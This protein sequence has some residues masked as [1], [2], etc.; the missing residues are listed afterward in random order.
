VAGISFL[1]A[2]L[3][4]DQFGVGSIARGL[5]LAGFGVAGM[6]IGRAAGAGV[7]RFGRV[8]VVVAGSAIST[9]LV[10]SLGLAA[11]PVTLAL[12][13]TL[14]GVG[15]SLVWAGLNVL[16]VEA[17]PGN[18]AGGT[19]VIGAFK[20]AGNAIAPLLW[21][22]LYHADVRLG[23]LG[24]GLMAALPGAFVLPLRRRAKV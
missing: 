4:A 10:T 22:P 19:S 8:P 18:R 7:D 3:A 23:F 1:V 6:L 5:V 17:V 24:A 12:L 15:S 2:L 13:W 16:A 20:F 21:L 14:A 11:G 9:V